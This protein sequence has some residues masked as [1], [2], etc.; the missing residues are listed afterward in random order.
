MPPGRQ[1]LLTQ[2]LMNQNLLK[3]KPGQ[4]KMRP[5]MMKVPM[6]TKR[7]FL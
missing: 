4:A 6:K 5:Q 7:S 2:K 3:Q 1:L